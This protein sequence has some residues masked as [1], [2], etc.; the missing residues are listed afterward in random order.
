MDKNTAYRVISQFRANNCKS[1]ALAI[2]LDEAL[3]A[4]KPVATNNVYVIRL[5]IKPHTCSNNLTCIILINKYRIGYF[6]FDVSKHPINWHV[7]YSQCSLGISPQ[8]MRRITELLCTILFVQQGS[9]TY[10]IVRFLAIDKHVKIELSYVPSIYKHA[11]FVLGSV[12]RLEIITLSCVSSHSL[13]KL[14]DE[15]LCFFDSKL[16]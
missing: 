12:F 5:Q 7:L 15:F 1:G 4:L 3:K 13:T 9:S 11:Y 14:T 6:S 8:E 10:V 2:A 16:F